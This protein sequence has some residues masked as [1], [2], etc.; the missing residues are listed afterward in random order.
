VLVELL[1]GQQRREDALRVI[2]A[3]RAAL[4]GS[5]DGLYVVSG[6]YARLDRTLLAHEAL[7]EVLRIDPRHA[8]AANDLGYSLADEGGDLD[9]AERLI[10]IAVEQEPDTPAF[11]D[12]LG[13]VLY[14]RGRFADA[15]PWLARAIE[16]DVSPD[17]VVLDHLADVRWRLDRR[18][19]A[20]ELWKQ[21]LT[22]LERQPNREPSLKL[23]IQG[24]LRAV[25]SGG[26]VEVAPAAK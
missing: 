3:A 13:W 18:D 19:D 9:E 12:S 7:R 26:T 14:K 22:L 21:A 24:K 6:L 17:P 4:A 1:D 11:L 5:P 16:I 10:R 2:D 23:K 25:E 15:E 20:V 8:S